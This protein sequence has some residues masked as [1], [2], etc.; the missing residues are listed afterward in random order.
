MVEHLS[1]EI[2][3]HLRPGRVV[4]CYAASEWIYESGNHTVDRNAPGF[5]R[6]KAPALGM[7]LEAVSLVECTRLKRR[8]WTADVQA[9]HD[10]LSAIIVKIVMFGVRSFEDAWRQRLEKF[11]PALERKLLLLLFR[12]L[13]LPFGYYGVP[14]ER[15]IGALPFTVTGKL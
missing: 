2:V 12:E 10:L 9:S 14:V 5:A 6:A 3:I 8:S 15:S 13:I 7:G 1:G 11:F 4:D